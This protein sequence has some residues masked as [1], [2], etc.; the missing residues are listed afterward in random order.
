[1]CWA[2]KSIEALL[3]ELW[4]SVTNLDMIEVFPT[5]CQTEPRS[6]LQ[7]IILISNIP[8]FYSHSERNVMGMRMSFLKIGGMGKEC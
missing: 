2:E 7:I 5:H 3:R 6:E 8:K 4:I 1:M